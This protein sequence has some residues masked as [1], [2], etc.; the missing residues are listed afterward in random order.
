MPEENTRWCLWCGEVLEPEEQEEGL[1]EECLLN[2]EDF[3]TGTKDGMWKCDECGMI[4]EDE[5]E[6]KK[7]MKQLI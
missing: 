4:L 1:C 5:N 6:C 3:F 2:W 7:H